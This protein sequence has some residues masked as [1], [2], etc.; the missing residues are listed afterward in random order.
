MWRALVPLRW[1]EVALPLVLITLLLFLKQVPA[2][3]HLPLARA[4]GVVAF[5]YAAFLALRLMQSEE[6]YSA[7][8]WMELRPSLVEYFAAYGG[9]ALS[10]ALMAAVI[11][12]GWKTVDPTEMIAAFTAS[13]GLGAS[14]WL[15]AVNGLFAR[16]RWN[17][18]QLEKRSAFGRTVAIA[19][20]DVVSCEPNWRGVV[21][22]ARD[23]RRV[24][25]SQFQGGAAELARHATNRARRNGE[26]ASKAFA[27]L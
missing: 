15:V 13:V 3:E 14:A 25:F 23:G 17:N 7:G 16:V 26:T 22:G 4:A 10:V 8:G 20:S 21:I 1:Q 9:A 5:G 27:P 12:A 11:L 24:V 19:W 18:R 6:A 2:V